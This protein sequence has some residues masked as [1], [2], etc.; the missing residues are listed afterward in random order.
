MGMILF[1]EAK[2]FQLNYKTKKTIIPFVL[3]DNDIFANIQEP[4]YSLTIAERTRRKAIW[5]RINNAMIQKGYNSCNINFYTM[6]ISV[7][8]PLA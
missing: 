3:S 8:S 5:N 1:S 6:T 2:S 4:D 7:D